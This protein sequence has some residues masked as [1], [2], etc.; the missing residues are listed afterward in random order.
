LSEEGNFTLEMAAAYYMALGAAA[1]RHFSQDQKRLT[2][3]LN[4]ITAIAGGAVTE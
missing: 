3:F 1:R 2:A 4:D